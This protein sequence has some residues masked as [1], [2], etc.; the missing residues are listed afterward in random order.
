MIELLFYLALGAFWL[1]KHFASAGESGR[2]VRR[3][4]RVGSWGRLDSDTGLR[5]SRSLR[6]QDR[7]AQLAKK[8]KG[9]VV[10]RGDTLRVEGRFSKRD[11]I[12]WVHELGAKGYPVEFCVRINAPGLEFELRQ[13]VGDRYRVR[14]VVRLNEKSQKALSRLEQPRIAQGLY[15]LFGHLECNEVTIRDGWLRARRNCSGKDL[16]WARMEKVLSRVAL[17]AVAWEEGGDAPQITV[18][19][20][21]SDLSTRQCPFCRDSL[22]DGHGLEILA[23]KRCGTVQHSECFEEAGRRCSSMGCN[24]TLVETL[25]GDRALAHQPVRLDVGPC[26]TCGHTQLGCVRGEVCRASRREQRHGN[27]ARRQLRPRARRSQQRQ[28]LDS[29]Q[30]PSVPD[31]QPPAALDEHRSGRFGRFEHWESRRRRSN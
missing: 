12:V 14:E 13:L 7:V 31:L 19:L 4:S 25:T 20:G 9:E 10:G 8:L 22:A 3:V 11:V 5:P 30:G 16:S 28:G 21:A 29:Y 26:E 15:S 2:Q 23:C 1:F 18:K 6:R 24:S 17:L 27:R